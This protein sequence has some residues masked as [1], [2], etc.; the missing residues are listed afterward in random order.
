MECDTKNVFSI[1]YSKFRC[2]VIFFKAFLIE[3]INWFVNRKW[4]RI[5][6]TTLYKFWIWCA[7]LNHLV[8]Q[9]DN[10]SHI[11]KKRNKRSVD[12]SN[13]C[14]TLGNVCFQSQSVKYNLC[15]VGH[16]R[17]RGTEKIVF[18][19]CMPHSA[20][21]YRFWFFESSARS[22]LL[23]QFRGISPAFL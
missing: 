11:R 3:D 17:E 12:Y 2:G 20:I 21:L 22:I 10:L 19:M 23:Y 4:Y 6:S 5:S 14:D 9:W 1:F 13:L 18:T 15:R 16:F 8:I 7:L